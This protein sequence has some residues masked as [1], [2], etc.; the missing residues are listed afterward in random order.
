MMGDDSI[1]VASSP[2]S[3]GQTPM[4]SHCAAEFFKAGRRI[5]Q[6]KKL[7]VFDAEDGVRRDERISKS[8]IASG[9]IRRA[10]LNSLSF[11]NR[12]VILMTSSRQG[13]GTESAT[14]PLRA[15]AIPND[16]ANYRIH[17]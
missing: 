12:T 16:C 4:F 9:L 2:A 8:R 5:E 15:S 6:R 1:V 14:D 11:S 17:C 7:S 3:T 10:A 13:F